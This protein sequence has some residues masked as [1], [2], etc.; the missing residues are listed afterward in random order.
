[1]KILVIQQKMI[2]DV[3]T[4]SIIFAA[5]REKY[6]TARLHYLIHRHTAAVVE[7][8]PF[9]DELILFD[10]Q[11]DQKP[12][13]FFNLLKSIKNQHYDIV[14]D[15]YSKINTALITRY[16]GAKMRISYDKWYTRKAYTHTFKNKPKS[17]T[18]A[19]LA[20]E[21]RMQLLK[22]LS[23]DFP[24]EIKPKIYLSSEEK[25]AA[26]MRL[27]SDGISLEKPLFMC[28]IL[29]SSAAKT[30]PLPYMAQVLDYMVEQTNAQLLF[31]YIPKQVE[32]AAALY[33]LCNSE[34]QKHI[35]FD[36]F[37]TSLREFMA[38]TS[39]CDALIGNEGGAVNMA[40]ALEVP[41]FAIF[42]PQIKKENWSIY[43]DGRQNV[44]VHLRDFKPLEL[45][46]LSPSEITKKAPHFYELLEPNLIFAK[47]QTFMK[48]STANKTDK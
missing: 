37:G 5:L 42:S 14:I 8:N 18:N 20:I 19:G 2:G 13:A 27:E 10:P 4:S 11:Q 30:Y 45:Q 9:I 24:V 38:I 26:R 35:F 44:S 46:G 28:G 31:N 32:E 23:S 16:S 17:E 6:P 41:T 21:N 15:V 39:Y 48:T 29:G 43:E 3:L 7:N 12:A 47:L 34:T 33:D 22:A 36:I 25:E 1:M 40:K